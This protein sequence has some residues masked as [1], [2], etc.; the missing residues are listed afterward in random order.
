LDYVNCYVNGLVAKIC[1]GSCAF[2]VG[3]FKGEG[4]KTFEYY[5]KAYFTDGSTATSAAKSFSIIAELKPTIAATFSPSG[6]KSMLAYQTGQIGVFVTLNG[7]TL[8]SND[9]Y[10][11]GA[12]AKSC[13][14]TSCI[15]TARMSDLLGYEPQENTILSFYGVASF[16]SGITIVSTTGSVTV[17]PAQAPQ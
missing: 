8:I 11:N 9:I 3:P 14:T 7:N 1:Y 10:I 15:L 12:K 5:A 13:A 6:Q 17:I 16:N 2:Q 4:G